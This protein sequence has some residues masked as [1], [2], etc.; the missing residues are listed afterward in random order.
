MTTLINV[1]TA[2]NGLWSTMAI[3]TGAVAG[4]CTIILLILYLFYRYL[5][6]KGCAK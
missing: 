6:A 5:I 3:V 1:Y 2:K 4:S